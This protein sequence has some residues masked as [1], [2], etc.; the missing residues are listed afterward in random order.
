MADY[1]PEY[2]AYR[3]EFAQQVREFAEKLRAEIPLREYVSMLRPDN[4]PLTAVSGPMHSP[5][6]MQGDQHPSFLAYNDTQAWKDMG[7][8]ESGRGIFNLAAA[9]YGISRDH[10]QDLVATVARDAGRTAEMPRFQPPALG[11]SGLNNDVLRQI[12]QR[13]VLKA[14]SAYWQHCLLHDSRAQLARAQLRERNIS[15]QTVMTFGLGYAPS[16]QPLPEGMDLQAAGRVGLLRKWGQAMFRDRI[17]I[18]IV[19][20]RH[21]L[22]GFGGRDVSGQDQIRYLNSPE[23]ELFAKKQILFGL[24]HCV[25]G[26]PLVLCEGYMDAMALHQAGFNAAAVMSASVTEE[27]IRLLN[28]H[29][30]DVVICL[31]GDAAGQSG[32]VKSAGQLLSGFRGRTWVAELPDGLDP[33]D[34]LRSRGVDAMHQVL[35]S[36]RRGHH[37]LMDQLQGVNG[38]QAIRG[39]ADLPLRD[40]DFRTWMTE[41]RQHQAP[42]LRRWFTQLWRQEERAETL[43]AAGPDRQPMA[44]PEAMRPAIRPAVPPEPVMPSAQ[45]MS[46]PEV[47]RPQIRP[48]VLP[49]PVVPQVRSAVSS[50][51]ET[52]VQPVVQPEKITEGSK[53][54]EAEHVSA[55]WI[56]DALGG[57]VM[58]PAQESRAALLQPHASR[59]VSEQPVSDAPSVREPPSVSDIMNAV[60]AADSTLGRVADQAG[61]QVDKSGFSRALMRFVPHLQDMMQMMPDRGGDL[62]TLCDQLRDIDEEK[63]DF[64]F[65]PGVTDQVKNRCYDEA[66]KVADLLRSVTENPQLLVKT[67]IAKVLRQNLR[68][69]QGLGH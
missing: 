46:P 60:P 68:S 42:Q 69:Q 18:P 3:R 44:Q 47:I 10:F 29:T 41:T 20:E 54:A 13:K 58:L 62:G 17:M 52:V 39:L 26:Q 16:D 25:P 45:P 14:A 59:M 33:D 12:E 48:A 55:A 30:G 63:A 1:D 23:T 8:G 50:E 4:R 9:V 49:D 66:H 7:T 34:M 31:D 61:L 65:A 2:E 36:A 27:Q 24:P 38:L 37:Y 6:R 35:L 21:Q 28:R 43:T 15:M 5:L 57:T 40:E 22:C 32:T 19:D 51:S 11:G 56:N 53:A 64:A 67:G